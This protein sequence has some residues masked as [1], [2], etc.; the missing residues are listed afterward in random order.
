MSSIDVHVPVS[1][2][3]DGGSGQGPSLGPAD[4]CPGMATTAAIAVNVAAER[5]TLWVRVVRFVMVLVLP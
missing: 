3:Q 1:F 5:M 2:E 4:A